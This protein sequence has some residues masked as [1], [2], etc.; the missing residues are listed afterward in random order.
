MAREKDC[1]IWLS[2]LSMAAGMLFASI[3]ASAAEDDSGQGGGGTDPSP[4]NTTDGARPHQSDMRRAAAAEPGTSQGEPLKQQPPRAALPDSVLSR[5]KYFGLLYPEFVE[6][7]PDEGR[8]RFGSDLAFNLGS[9]RINIMA[10]RAFLELATILNAEDAQPLRVTVIGHVCEIPMLRP[11]MV[12][13][14]KDNQGLSEARA[15]AVRTVLVKAGVPANRV[16]AIGKG[17]AEPITGSDTPGGLA[18]NRRVDILLRVASTEQDTQPPRQHVA[19]IFAAVAVLVL[20]VLTVRLL[21]LR[22]RP[23]QHR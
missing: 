17:D 4:G 6:F 7:D 14:F 12:A 3:P 8:L 11:E 5:L 23:G 15:K 1:T 9:D 16:E 18:R 19:V 2:L 22:R 13:R 10:E 20:G 21:K